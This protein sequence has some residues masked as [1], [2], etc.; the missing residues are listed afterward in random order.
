MQVA[1]QCKILTLRK[2]RD[3][4]NISG[5]QNSGD[6]QYVNQNNYSEEDQCVG[7]YEQN[8]NK[9]QQVNKQHHRPTRW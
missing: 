4:G 9:Q 1:T 5:K 8:L 6:A 7:Y 3:A 2:I